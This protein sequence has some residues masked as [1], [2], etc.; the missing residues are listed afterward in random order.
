MLFDFFLCCNHKERER[1]RVNPAQGQPKNVS[2]MNPLKR[3]LNPLLGN[4]LRHNLRR[5][6][7]IL[8]RNR[9]LLFLF[10]VA[11]I[12][13]LLIWNLL[14]TA[15]I[16]L[17]SHNHYDSKLTSSNRC[18][19]MSNTTQTVFES[20][21]TKIIRTFTLLEVTHFLCYETLWTVLKRSGMRK[22][23][24]GSLLLTDAC[25][26]LC[27][28]N[29]DLVKHD[30]A[31][32][33]RRF[34]NSAIS[35]EYFHSDGIYILKPMASMFAELLPAPSSQEDPLMNPDLFTIHA[36]IHVFEKDSTQDVYRKVGWKSRILPPTMCGQLHC[37][38][39]NL[40]DSSHKPLGK[41]ALFSSLLISVPNEGIEIQKYHYPDSWW[42]MAN[43]FEPNCSQ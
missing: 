24:T 30:E 34:R 39:S 15:G 14:H 35:L 32:I 10:I 18:S 29:E 38:P 17:N 42:T 31:L 9:R 43:Y 4:R 36:R 33:V 12:C 25:F 8:H 23:R 37:F 13:L 2:T 26:N 21:V 19:R 3:L 1:E 41:L 11:S 6:R 22:P 27:V 20:F 16:P 28:L 7:L 5:V 40:L